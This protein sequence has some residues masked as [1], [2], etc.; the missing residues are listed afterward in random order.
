MVGDPETA[1][2]MADTHSLCTALD[3]VQCTA[4]KYCKAYSLNSPL[5]LSASLS[6]PD[7]YSVSTPLSHTR[8]ARGTAARALP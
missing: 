7:S 2:S 4:L 3:T 8:G 1:D 5:S 6:L